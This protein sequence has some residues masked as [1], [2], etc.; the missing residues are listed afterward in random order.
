[1]N[2][3]SACKRPGPESP[4]PENSKVRRPKRGTVLQRDLKSP[5]PAAP[6]PARST[7]SAGSAGPPALGGSRPGAALR[8]TGRPPG[9]V[10]V[11]R[12]RNRDAGPG[13]CASR[14]P[15]TRTSS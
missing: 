6:P 4:G 1:M 10:R 7:P 11:T 15:V 9:C 2:L 8:V 3:I 12:S 5:G 13:P 14:P